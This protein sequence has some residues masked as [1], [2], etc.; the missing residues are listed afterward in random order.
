MKR[1]STKW[2]RADVAQDWTVVDLELTRGDAK[3]TEL[4]LKY[5]AEDNVQEIKATSSAVKWAFRGCTN[6]LLGHAI[7]RVV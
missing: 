6:I 4:L 3:I 5:G 7:R 2:T 1:C